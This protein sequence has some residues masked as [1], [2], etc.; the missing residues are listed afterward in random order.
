MVFSQVVIA[1]IVH[2]ITKS[3]TLSYDTHGVDKCKAYLAFD[4]IY[5]LTRAMSHNG[6]Y[7]TQIV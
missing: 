1:M 7:W 4:H 5:K 3:F 2:F 6:V